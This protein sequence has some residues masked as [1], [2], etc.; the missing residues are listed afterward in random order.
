MWG[1]WYVWVEIEVG[2]YSLE[3]IVIEVKWEGGGDGF[4]FM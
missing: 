3:D 4:C 1:I 2:F